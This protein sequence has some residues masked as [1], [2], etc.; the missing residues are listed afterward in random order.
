ME[1]IFHEIKAAIK[2]NA[3]E[4]KWIDLDEGQLEHFDKP[5]VD[6]P[7]LLVGF[8]QANYSN[9][10]DMQTADLSITIKLAFKIW[11]KFNAA[12]PLANQ[13]TAFA[14]FDII[15]KVNKA[16]HGLPGDDRTELMRVRMQKNNS[17]DPKVY[18]IV[19]ECAYFDDTTMVAYESIPKPD[20]QLAQN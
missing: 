9:T 14:H 17:P 19:Y 12:V 1:S 7:C 8:P 18:E 15:R 16:L 6:Y 2:A 4:I 11:E 13:P 3:P 20:L 5:P 10:G